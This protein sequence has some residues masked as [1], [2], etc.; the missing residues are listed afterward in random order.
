MITVNRGYMYNPDDNEVLITE[1][2]YEAATDTK[3]GS[4][5]NNLSY[6]AIPNEIKEKIEATASLS[7]VESI[8]M[9]QPLA[10]LY[11]NEINIYGKP[12]KLY[13]EYTNI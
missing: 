9:S 12:E 5:M 11:Q 2:Y 8:E 6:S 10:V 3:L 7:Y 1:I 4:K 13:F